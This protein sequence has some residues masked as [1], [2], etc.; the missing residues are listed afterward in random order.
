MGIYFLI[1]M[2]DFKTNYVGDVEDIELLRGAVKEWLKPDDLFGI[3][4][5][6]NLRNLTR[7]QQFWGNW[8]GDY[9]KR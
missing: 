4:H 1:Q 6:K 8:G 5:R 7:L 3:L 9:L 2:G